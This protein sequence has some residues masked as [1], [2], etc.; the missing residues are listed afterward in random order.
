MK[1]YLVGGAVRDILLGLEPKDRDYVV[2]GS[3]PEEMIAAG[4]TQVGKSFPVF[5]HPKTGDEYAL[6]RK[7]RK[8]GPGYNGFEVDF[9]PSVTL[10]EDLSRRDLTM[11]SIAY[12]EE[13]KKF[14]DPFGGMKDIEDKT[15]RHVGD[16]FSEDPL[17]VMRV[18]RFV[19]RYNF[20][21]AP[22]TFKL[23]TEV[24]QSPD[25]DK[26]SAERIWVELEKIFDEPYTENAIDC[27]MMFGSEKSVRLNRLLVPSSHFSTQRSWA[28]KS[29]NGKFSA[30][31]KLLMY[32]NIRSMSK[33]ET[34]S[35]KV[36]TDLKVE[37]DFLDDMCLTLLHFSS[38]KQ[39]VDLDLVE[40]FDRYRNHLK[41]GLLDKFD[42]LTQKMIEPTNLAEVAR[43]VFA[44][45]HALD[46]TK[47][48]KGMKGSE[49]KEFVRQK[50]LDVVR[51]HV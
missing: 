2:V 22:E 50:K 30:L 45:L 17:R 5:L 23:C 12:D 7:E 37:I 18:A 25:F 4:F 10:E 33:E 44:E 8:T 48:V 16:A 43:K 35:L 29:F 34:T 6:A 14:I 39:F 40:V 27:L 31:E 26:L 21:I 19:A 13:T 9:D 38:D 11:N 49:I 20:K 24:M 42:T 36:P 1:K 15:I 3:S 47:D 46:F 41:N 51:K 32:T 28:T